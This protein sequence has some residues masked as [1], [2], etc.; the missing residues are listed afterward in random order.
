MPSG[1]RRSPW[2]TMPANAGR[3]RRPATRRQRRSRRGGLGL[4][5]RH[6]VGQFGLDGLD[7]D[8]LFRVE[9]RQAAH[10]VDQ[11]AHIARPAMLLQP[12]HRLGRQDLGRQAVGRRRLQVVI[13][14]LGNVVEPLAQRRQAN[15][16]DVQAIE[17]IFAE[18]ALLRPRRR[19][20]LSRRRCARRPTARAPPTGGTRRPGA[21]AGGASAARAASRRSRRG[22][23]CRRRPARSGP[24]RALRRAGE[25]A[26]LVA[27]QLA[28]DQLARDRPPVERHERAVATRR[29][30]CSA[31]ATSSL[32]VPDSPVISTVTSVARSGARARDRSPGWLACGRSAASRRCGGWAARCIG[33]AG[34]DSARFT[35]EISLVEVERL[36]QVFEGA[37]LGGAYSSEQR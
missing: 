15:R 7:A 16:H 23:A 18:Q 2:G 21:R 32:P 20:R 9:R 22:T 12:R 31:R 1:G 29:S 11:L 27:E 26:A 28:L 37:T 13:G 10:Q 35:T 24:R 3:R 8:H 5:R 14:K 33:V 4:D 34:A 25:R 19:S 17:Q 30:S 6:R 36:G